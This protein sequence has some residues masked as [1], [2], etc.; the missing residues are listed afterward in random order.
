MATSAA[1][2]ATI[3]GELSK[4]YKLGVEIQAVVELVY[5]ALC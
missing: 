2:L 1:T 3:I 5:N 4:K